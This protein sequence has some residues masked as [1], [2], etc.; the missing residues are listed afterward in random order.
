MP[1]AKLAADSNPQ[2]EDIVSNSSEVLEMLCVKDGEDRP[3]HSWAAVC[4]DGCRIDNGR[5]LLP[6]GGT[7][8]DGG[9]GAPIRATPGTVPHS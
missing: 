9:T 7:T 3:L 4:V 2:T 5:Q 1:L 6:I 8:P